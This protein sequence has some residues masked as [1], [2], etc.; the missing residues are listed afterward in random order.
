M[1]VKCKPYEGCHDVIYALLVAEPL[2]LAIVGEHSLH[3]ISMLCLATLDKARSI[4]ICPDHILIGQIKLH[5]P[6]F[7]AQLGFRGHSDR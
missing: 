7:L 6:D 1:V 3:R 2:R 5:R 4:S